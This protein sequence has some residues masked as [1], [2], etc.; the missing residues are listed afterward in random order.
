MD[1]AGLHFELLQNLHTGVVVHLP[2][3][4]IVFCNQRASELLGLSVDQMM[5]KT[6][7]SPSWRFVAEDGAP[8]VPNQY[9]VSLVIANLLPLDELVLGVQSKQRDEITW[10]LVSAFPDF[11]HDGSLKQVVVNFYSIA[12]RKLLEQRLVA[13]EAELDDLYNQ[14][15]CGY[16]SLDANDKFSH[17]N[18]TLLAWLG[19]TRADLVGKKGLLDFLPPNQKQPFIARYQEMRTVGRVDEFEV[20]V[21]SAD[22]GLRQVSLTAT[23]VMDA[24]GDFLMSRLVLYDITALHKAKS[25]L[26]RIQRDQEAMLD[27]ELI[28]I[29]K[30]QGRRVIWVNKAMT[31]LYGYTTSEL[32]GQS[33]RILYRGD[34]QFQALGAAAYPLLKCGEPYRTQLEMRRKDGSLIWVDINGVVLLPEEE[35]SIWFVADISDLKLYQFQIEQLAFHDC[36]TGLPNRTIFADRIMQALLIATR[37]QTCLAVCYVDLDGFKQLNDTYGHAAG[38]V[39]LKE[40]AHRLQHA[41]RPNDTACRLGG[42]EFALLITQFD[43]DSEYQAVLQRALAEI[44]KPIALDGAT[45]VRVSVSMGVA[46]YPTDGTDAEML[47]LKAD[48]AMYQSKHLGRNRICVFGEAN[49][50]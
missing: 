47:L 6:A 17:I 15:P 43:E 13:S 21:I 2:D 44:R 39:V 16:C 9:P 25:E 35:L 14:A 38:D 30:I 23:A 1:S 5:G 7:M 19:E 11:Y 24:D 45:E 33:S 3:T 4:S 8:L 34:A 10:L 20:K 36:L 18:A 49:T 31:R 12:K 26:E 48:Q 28:G 29:V 32:V 40:V 22:S 46:R 27:N 41:M 42:D 50:Q 37:T